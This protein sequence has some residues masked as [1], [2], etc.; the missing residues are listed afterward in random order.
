MVGARA[1]CHIGDQGKSLRWGSEAQCRS[2]RVIMPKPTPAE[3]K[4]TTPQ[5]GIWLLITLVVTNAA[6]AALAAALAWVVSNYW[7]YKNYMLEEEKGKLELF[8][9]I[10]NKQP[11]LALA[12]IRYYLDKYGS[13]DHD[14]R[15]LLEAVESWISSTPLQLSAAAEFTASAAFGNSNDAEIEYLTSDS[16]RDR[17]SGEARREFAEHLVFLYNSPKTTKQKLLITKLGQAIMLKTDGD[18]QSNRVNRY[19]SLTFYLLPTGAIEN[20]DKAI[21]ESLEQ[22]KYTED[23]KNPSFKQNVDH[24]IAKQKSI[25]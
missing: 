24:A 16:I 5:R 6:T 18:E 12:L 23:Y 1:G 21:F 4:R 11:T 7:Q 10:K 9:L 8:D 20:N 22:L 14:Y 2:F 19:I 3:P 15:D 13:S 25:P 17:F